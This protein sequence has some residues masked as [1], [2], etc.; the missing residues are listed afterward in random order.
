MASNNK[1]RRTNFMEEN[2]VDGILEMDIVKNNWELFE[3][4]RPM[5]FFTIS[6]SY[7]QRPDLL[8]LKLY[9]KMSYW[10]I[11]LKANNIDDVWNDL[12]VGDI[13]SVP[14]IRDVEDF[15]S[16]FRKRRKSNV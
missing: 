1:Y 14:D 11:I 6:R 2:E 5:T 8:S 4:K 15:Y 9:G 10:W 13:I 7:I 3:I 12:E 16:S